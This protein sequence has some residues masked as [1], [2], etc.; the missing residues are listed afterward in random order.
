MVLK[1]VV[2]EVLIQFV[3]MK[4]CFPKY[5][6]YVLLRITM[7]ES[8]THIMINIPSRYD[9]IYKLHLIYVLNKV[10]LTIKAL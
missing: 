5:L 6:F 3:A 2:F 10:E 4:A 8:T 7:H 1:L 9:V